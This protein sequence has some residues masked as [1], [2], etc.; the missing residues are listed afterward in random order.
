MVIRVYN[1]HLD[2]YI[3]DSSHVL[4]L[5]YRNDEFDT[6]NYKYLYNKKFEYLRQISNER[7]KVFTSDSGK[8]LSFLLC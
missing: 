1:Q 8:R 4:L 7:T 5:F 6:V 3:M 2:Q